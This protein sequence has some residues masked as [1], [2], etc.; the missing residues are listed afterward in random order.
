MEHF[1]VTRALFRQTCDHIE[2][3]R[4]ILDAANQHVHEQFAFETGRF[5]LKNKEK[6]LNEDNA[7]LWPD[8]EYGFSLG[9]WDCADSP[10]GQCVYGKHGRYDEICLIC[11]NPDERK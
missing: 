9:E 7:D 4:K 10:T 1:K 8:N 11:G 6:Y 2:M 3:N 5:M